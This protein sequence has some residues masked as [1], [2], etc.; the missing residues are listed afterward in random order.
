[1]K[2]A[3]TSQNRRTVT[4]HAG[5]CRKFWIYDIDGGV[6]REKTLCELPIEQTL[7]VLEGEVPDPL[8]GIS[9]LITQGAGMGMRE[10]MARHGIEVILTRLDDPDEAVSAWLAGRASAGESR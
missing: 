9:A 6:I 7:H 4:G 5:K 3:V 2:V 1:M 10:R 8:R